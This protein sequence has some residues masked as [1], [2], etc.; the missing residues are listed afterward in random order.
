MG[1]GS[2]RVGF[3]GQVYTK[4]ST[5]N[6][7]IIPGDPLT[8]SSIPGVAVKAV[9]AGQIVGKAMEALECTSCEGKILVSISVSWYDPSIY[10]TSTGDLSTQKTESPKAS[11][12][13]SPIPEIDEIH[14][15]II[16]PLASAAPT[17]VQAPQNDSALEIQNASGSAVTTI[18]SLGNATSS[19]SLSAETIEEKQ[20]P[21]IY[22]F[23][24]GLIAFGPTSLN[25][26]SI[27]GQ[28]SIGNI[29]GGFI[30]TQNSINAMG[31][32]L[33]L[34]PLRQGAL[35]IMGG[36]V[37]IDTD[38]NLKVGGDAQF[39]KDVIVKGTLSANII[40]PIPE[41]DLVIRLGSSTNEG[42]SSI[43]HDSSFIIQNSSNSAVFS[44]NQLGDIIASGSGTFSKI[45]LNI[46][47]NA[48]ALSSRELIATGS[49]GA[50]F[51]HAREV[52]V[53]INNNLVT[54]NSLIYIT[55]IGTSSGQTPFLL[56]QIPEI[57][58]TVG[59][60]SVSAT[61]TPFNWLIIN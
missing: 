31:A 9:S 46:A 40:S 52:E 48:L 57:S 10:L 3:V 17:D 24:E 30:I 50:A 53:T 15:D 44:V 38:G 19:G 36:L 41:S 13:I 33:E 45:N 2:I 20:S 35:S 16:S 55:P 49:A 59:I 29:G 54:D 11:I 26:T 5:M 58:F 32:N 61:N 25:D 39:S 21:N 4:V 28:L 56:R 37:Y 27:I 23:P 14:T 43:I 12:I 1:S 51:V 60:A 34:Q 22:T 42:S 7:N 18:D 6:G 8:S 47:K